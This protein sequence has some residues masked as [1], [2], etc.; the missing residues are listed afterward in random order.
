MK[1]NID[2]S[3]LDQ[4]VKDMGAGESSFTL[5]PFEFDQFDFDL[6]D[7]I[8]IHLEDLE[9]REGI[10]SYK[11]RQV[12][13]YI[14]DQ[15]KKIATVLENPEDGKRFH[16]SDCKTLKHMR[17]SNRF[18]RY[19]VTNDLSG[20]FKVNGL[21]IL[22]NVPMEGT[23]ELKVCKNCL[24]ALNYHGYATKKSEKKNVFNSFKI[25]TF[26]E[27]YST[28]FKHLPKR[29]HGIYESGYAKN[30]DKISASYRK[31]MNYTCEECKTDFSSKK[32][33]LHTHH[34][35]G[36]KSDNSESNL[37]AVCIDCH[38]KEPMHEHIF[39]KHD[40]MLKIYELRRLQGKMNINS[41]SDVF[42]LADT[43]L[44]GY[45]KYAQ[46]LFDWELPEIGYPISNNGGKI[47]LD[48]A[49]PDRKIAVVIAKNELNASFIDW[50]IL[51]L[52]DE[53]GRLM[54]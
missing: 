35:S 53:M 40:D 5:D 23:A 15:A 6:T 39:I 25:N 45:L 33:L 32:N 26:F 27:T 7:G 16:V 2:F 44:H 29:T 10:L 22:T 42:R 28:V 21:D 52:G 12:L 30:W 11:G 13:L 20:K 19:V 50:T 47:I 31:K 46:E 3:L 49:W 9:V 54:K 36:V 51:S 18:E 8:E 24:S 4:C 34:I 48:I 17:N 38:K 43:S 41:W 14:P 1:L 37:K